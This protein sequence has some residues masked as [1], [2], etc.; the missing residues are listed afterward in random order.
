MSSLIPGGV[1]PPDL[2]V[3]PV[4]MGK[5][6]HL[7]AF[8]K[9]FG[10]IDEDDGDEYK[11]RRKRFRPNDPV[12]RQLAPQKM[13]SELAFNVLFAVA[14]SRIFPLHL[15]LD[16]MGDKSDAFLAVSKSLD[17][18]DKGL[19]FPIDPIEPFFRE[20]RKKGII[21]TEGLPSTELLLER[22][23]IREEPEPIL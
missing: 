13:T 19:V 10:G 22:K 15:L 18:T 6:F 23:C 20:L 9:K 16:K 5:S 14:S 3:F 12:S 21:N 2:F 17:A 7:T 4:V 1:I 8:G 11:P